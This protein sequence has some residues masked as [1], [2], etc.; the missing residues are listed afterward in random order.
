MFLS[1][2]ADADLPAARNDVII[3]MDGLCPEIMSE[4]L[5]RWRRRGMFTVCIGCG[6]ASAAASAAEAAL[7]M[8]ID[9]VAESRALKERLAQQMALDA[10]LTLAFFEAG[11]A[12]GEAPDNTGDALGRAALAL[13]KELPALDRESAEELIERHGSVRKA[14][15]AYLANVQGKL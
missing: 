3:A 8:Q 15:K 2:P 10:L 4:Q 13:M 6:V 5:R 11:A 14:A 12:P 7:V 1:L 9:P